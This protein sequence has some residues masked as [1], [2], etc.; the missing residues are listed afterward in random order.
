[1]HQT[2][3]PHCRQKYLELFGPPQSPPAPSS[4]SAPS[5]AGAS[6]NASDAMDVVESILGSHSPSDNADELAFADLDVEDTD[7]RILVDDSD[8][9]LDDSPELQDE[10][11]EE[12]AEDEDGVYFWCVANC[13][14]LC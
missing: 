9:E 4:P 10:Q 1:M 11:E 2:Q 14:S 8:V 12:E 5:D 6:D 3:N 7:I 13:V